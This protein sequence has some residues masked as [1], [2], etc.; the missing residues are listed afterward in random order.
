MLIPA[1]TGQGKTYWASHGLYDYL[2]ANSLTCLFLIQ[3]TRTKEQLKKEFAGKED[4]IHVNTYQSIEQSVLHNKPVGY[5]DFIV[6][7][8]AQY[9][10]SDGSF[11]HRT[12]VSFDWV[13]NQHNSIKIFMSATLNSFMNC[14]L[15]KTIVCHVPSGLSLF[16]PYDY[17]YIKSLTFFYGN[18]QLEQ[19]TADVIARNSKAVFFIQKAERALELYKKFKD[20]MIFSCS[21]G[22]KKYKKYMSKKLIDSI[23]ENESFDSAILITTAALDSGFTLQDEKIDTLVVD[24]VEPETVIQCVGR[25]RVVSDTDKIDLYIRG[26]SNGEL[27]RLLH[28]MNLDIKSV[29]EKDTDEYKYHINHERQNH[30]NGVVINQF[31]GYDENGQPLYV[32]TFNMSKIERLDYYAGYLFPDMMREKFGYD[33]YLARWFGFYDENTGWYSHQTASTKKQKLSEYLDSITGKAILGPKD[34]EPLINAIHVTNKNGTLLKS[35]ETLNGALKEYG[36]P[37]RIM[38]YSDTVE[39]KRYSSIWKVINPRS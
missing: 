22:N 33:K 18:D 16:Q 26:R 5:Y 11:N 9:F 25:K 23:V 14:L 10:T 6:C 1:Q 2:K 3:R 29:I 8:E 31:I 19:L 21:N 20:H 30:S 15:N 27:N 35:L 32:K 36:L 17:D 37:H 39:S 13:F 24:M 28:T 38:K 4:T 34:R 7:D 12:D